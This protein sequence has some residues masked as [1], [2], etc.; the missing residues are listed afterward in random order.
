METAASQSKIKRIDELGSILE[1]YRAENKKIVYCHG[2]F[3]LLHIGHIRHL[4]QARGYADILVVTVTPDR[5]VDKGPGRPAFPENLRAE[6]LASLG[7]VDY[8]AINEWPTAEQPL[9]LLKPNFYAKGAEFKGIKSDYTGKIDR[10]LRVV[11]EIGAEMVFTEDIV[12]SSSN[13][14]NRFLSNRSDDVEEYLQLFRRRYSIEYVRELVEKMSSLKVLVVG[15]AILDDYC[16]CDSIGKSKKDPVL[17]LQYRSND[18][19]IG[20]ALDVANQAAQYA[21]EVT[22]ATVLGERD[23]HDK[24]IRE[25]LRSNVQP[26]FVT[27][28]GAPTQ[29][30]RR[31]LDAYSFTKLLE[32][33]VTEGSDL[34]EEQDAEFCDW[35]KA[36]LD[37][38]DVIIA[39]D[40]GYGTISDRLVNVLCEHAPHLAVNTQSS[41][42]NQG[43]HTISR[44]PKADFICLGEHDFRLETRASSQ[45]LRPAM[46]E[47]TCRLSCKV[48][49][50]TCGRRGC[51]VSRR[52][53]SFV[54]CPAFTVSVVDRVGVGEAFFA[55]TSLAAALGSED[56]L[57]GFI[58]N[59]VGALAVGVIGTQK[60]IE[61]DTLNKYITTLLK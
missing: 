13:L 47:L 24:F 45:N 31:I 2:V 53:G 55:I 52:E 32:I 15:D 26:H 23:S 50:V 19:F 6:A 3:D 39:A 49:V 25:R 14:I 59:V 11:E 48:L 60:P 28:P 12:F 27:K 5:F 7:D 56:E 30:N 51:L 36:E 21:G 43:F 41:P 44:Y 46:D 38:Y 9:R 17:A 35:V 33:Y 29:V 1:I 34:P 42:S 40:F 54:A 4:R 57:I 18:L 16:Y 10:E 37:Y 8:V 20:G 58:G 61:K 22:L